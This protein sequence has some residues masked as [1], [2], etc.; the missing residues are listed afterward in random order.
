MTCAMLSFATG[1]VVIRF[2][3]VKGKTPILH[4]AFLSSNCFLFRKLRHF[5]HVIRQSFTILGTIQHVNNREKFN[6]SQLKFYM[7]ISL[8]WKNENVLGRFRETTR[9]KNLPTWGFKIRNEIV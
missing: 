9:K 3:T 7:T 1:K 6:I 5:C 4:T 8:S 2:L